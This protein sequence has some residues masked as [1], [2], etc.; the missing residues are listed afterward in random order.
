LVDR[1][2]Q[3]EATAVG[4]SPPAYLKRSL[5]R[6]FVWMEVLAEAT[7]A[8]IARGEYIDLGSYTQLVY[9]LTA[10]SRMI[11]TIRRPEVPQG[12]KADHRFTVAP[13]RLARR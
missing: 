1:I 10:L 7:E 12:L 5:I 3:I 11:G 13:T 8:G 2:K 6:R 9:A 4:G